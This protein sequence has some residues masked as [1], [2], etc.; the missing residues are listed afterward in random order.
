MLEVNFV[1]VYGGR[2]R[3][4]FCDIY[5]YMDLLLLQEK[6]IL[7]YKMKGRKFL[8]RFLTSWSI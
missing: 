6:D 4:A 5:I 1:T 7:M 8:A 3:G 2:K